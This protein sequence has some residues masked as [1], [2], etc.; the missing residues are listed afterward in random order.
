[1]VHRLWF[2]ISMVL[3]LWS[4]I[5]QWST[6]LCDTLQVLGLGEKRFLTNKVEIQPVL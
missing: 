4:T 3:Y 5:S 6:L 1:M 2:T